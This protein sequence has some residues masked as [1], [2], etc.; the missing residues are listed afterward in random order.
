MT[1]KRYRAAV[2]ALS[3]V[4]GAC[5]A[6]KYKLPAGSG[7]STSSATGGAGTGAPTTGGAS[8]SPSGGDAG[9]AGNTTGH[10]GTA[11]AAAA[12]KSGGG[13]TSEGGAGVTEPSACSPGIP[14]TSQVPRMK[15]AA[16]D[17][18]IRDLLGVSTLASAPGKKPSDLLY[19][20][21]D[22][23]LTADAWRL[24]QDTAATI[25]H[26]VITS[27][28][29]TKFSSCDAAAADCLSDTIKAFG[30]KAFRR[31]LTETEVTSFLRLADAPSPGTPDEV[32]EAMLYTFLASPSFI[33]LPELGSDREDDAIK[34]TSYEIATRLSFLLWNSV[35]DGAL[36]DA[37]DNDELET[38]AQILAQA[39]RM[40]KDT[41]AGAMF[42]A[43]GRAYLGISAGSHWLVGTDHDPTAYPTFSP[44]AVAP[45]LA[46]VDAFVEDVTLAGGS[47]SDL[48]LGN[49]GF[50]NRDTAAL[51]GLDPAPYGSDLTRVTLDAKQR[52]G[53]LTRAAFLSAF[54]HYDV[55]AP[56]LR[57]AFVSINVLG[58]DPGREPPASHE[59]PDPPGEYT[60]ERQVVEALTSS[61]A[62]CTGCHLYVNPAGF[63][64]ERY[65]AVGSWQ[66]VDRRGGAIDGTAD[67]ILS[68]S[69]TKTISSPVELMSALAAS[70]GAQ[71][72]FAEQ[73]VA[74]AS[75]RTPNA[76]DACI[77][78]KLAENVA[79]E[80]YAVRDLFADYTQADSFRLRTVGEAR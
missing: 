72:H 7:G 31:P 67:V 28:N 4:L 56:M 71:W 53:V 48:F 44:A 46:E 37:A 26:E 62:T 15:N 30:R 9:S 66:D 41:R 74:Y 73:L 42:T 60:T 18:V 70:E 35:P 21:S 8:A 17:N 5:G 59:P 54:S 49:V 16:Y 43:F 20:D 68:N 47:F 57:G 50:V 77:V 63:V 22:A 10:G 19:P 64:L 69:E 25:A 24:Y 2:V 11:A 52:P 14:A 33:M 32:A 34:L 80:G 1:R 55:T 27:S 76:M 45:L 40:L 79:K 23:P 13:G 29:K 12:G 39:Q 51:Y 65:D 3:A 61:S 36:D 58:L 6:S 75:G 38:E 78:D